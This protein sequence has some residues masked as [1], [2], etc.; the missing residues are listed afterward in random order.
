MP[1]VRERVSSIF[2]TVKKIFRWKIFWH[3]FRNFFS[4]EIDFVI[5]RMDLRISVTENAK[6]SFSSKAVEFNFYYFIAKE[7]NP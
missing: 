5:K 7:K 2:L 6:F 3:N 4:D 1:E